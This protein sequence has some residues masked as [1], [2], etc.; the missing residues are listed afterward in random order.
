MRG[1]GAAGLVLL[2]FISVAL[3]AA[4]LAAGLRRESPWLVHLSLGLATGLGFLAGLWLPRFREAGGGLVPFGL[5]LVAAVFAAVEGHAVGVGIARGAPG[6]AA[7]LLLP[8][9]AIAVGALVVAARRVR[10]GR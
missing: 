1:P 8:P 4:A 5:F 6:A 9:L 2:G 10:A 7:A 3:P